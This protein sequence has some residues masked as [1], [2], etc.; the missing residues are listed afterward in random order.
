MTKKKP[1]IIILHGW[2]TNQETSKKWQPFIKLLR[3]EAYDV[4]LLAIPGLS[5]PLTEVWSLDDFVRWLYNEVKDSEPIYLIGHSFGG[6]IATRFAAL[7][8]QLVEGLVLI[9]SAGIRDHSFVPTLKRTVFLIM[10][11]VGKFFLPFTFFK[12]ILYMIAREK[13]YLNAPPLLKRTMSSVLDHEVVADLPNITTNTLLI[14][15]ENDKVT[16]LK[17]GYQF[18]TLLPNNELQLIEGARHSPQ[19]T[20]HETVAKLVINFIQK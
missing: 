17:L 11:K 20:H 5:A 19:F 2:S 7:H 12:K 3:A 10:A 18:A 4:E 16:P 14:W 1:K 15:G 9:D 6:Q 13:D 8:S